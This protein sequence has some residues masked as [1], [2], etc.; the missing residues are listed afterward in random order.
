MCEV[1]LKRIEDFAQA[2]LLKSPT[3]T[4]KDRK[5]VKAL[6]EIANI[7]VK[8]YGLDMLKAGTNLDKYTEFDYLVEN[9]NL[10]D[11]KRVALEIVRNEE[12]YGG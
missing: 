10:K 8:T 9:S 7:D 11:L 3:T 6:A 1:F 12:N 2:T 5:A 4:D